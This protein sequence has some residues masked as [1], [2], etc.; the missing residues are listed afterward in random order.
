MAAVLL[1]QVNRCWANAAREWRRRQ[2]FVVLV[3]PTTVTLEMVVRDSPA[4]EELY[5]YPTREDHVLPLEDDLQTL[6]ACSA[7]MKSNENKA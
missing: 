3:R 4:V 6:C 5:L 1:A 7:L 2:R